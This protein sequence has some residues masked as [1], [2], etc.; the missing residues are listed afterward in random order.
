M[1]PHCAAKAG[2]QVSAKKNLERLAQ[3][4]GGVPVW[5]HGCISPWPT[6]FDCIEAQ[7][8]LNLFNTT[9]LHIQIH[10]IF[11]WSLSALTILTVTIISA[12]NR[13]WVKSCS[14][15][16][17]VTTK[18]AETNEALLCAKIFTTAKIHDRGHRYAKKHILIYCYMENL[19]CGTSHIYI[20]LCYCSQFMTVLL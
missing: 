2:D 15:V 3:K 11:L 18:V 8:Y 5:L 13:Y 17:L 12:P 20:Y 16:F 19:Y 14:L 1:T 9:G 4:Q 10:T 7:A 6:W